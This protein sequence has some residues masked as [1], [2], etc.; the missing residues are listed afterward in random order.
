MLNLIN[1]FQFDNLVRNRVPF[2]FINLHESLVPLF[3]LLEKMHIQTY[4]RLL[5]PAEVLLHIEEN[6]IPLDYAI[7]LICQDGKT[8]QELCANLE[9]KSYTNVY[10][11]NGG[12]QQLVTESKEV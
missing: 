9:K 10:V 1:F 4:E 3:T 12:Y 2:L 8:S 6:K 11:V 7:V 5:T